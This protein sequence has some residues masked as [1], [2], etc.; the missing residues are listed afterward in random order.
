[1]YLKEHHG[2]LSELGHLLASG[3]ILDGAKETQFFNLNFGVSPSWQDCVRVARIKLEK[4]FVHKAL[5][6][7]TVFP[8]DTVLNNGTLFWSWPKLIPSPVQWDWQTGEHSTIVLQ[9]ATMFAKI[10]GVVNSKPIDIAAINVPK[11]KPKD[12]SI[13]T[14]ESVTKEE[15][16]ITVNLDL[17]GLC[18]YVSKATLSDVEYGCGNIEY[19]TEL[20]R[21]LG[22]LRC[23]MYGIPKPT[24]QHA[25]G[26]I[27]GE[28]SIFF[29]KSER[30]NRSIMNVYQEP[31]HFC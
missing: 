8:A 9:L 21:S 20:C 25:I 12:K 26:L 27:T 15:S 31:F 4:Y 24:K 19:E 29:L 2:N 6:L 30:S 1:M 22:N 23:Q 17:S 3:K 10:L 11:F 5:H 7:T 28:L 14:D 13:V 18:D 16:E